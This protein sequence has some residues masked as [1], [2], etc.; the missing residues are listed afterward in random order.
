MNE[1]DLRTMIAIALAA[2]TFR[3]LPPAAADFFPPSFNLPG[4]IVTDDLLSRPPDGLHRNGHKKA[5]ETQN[6]GIFE[7]F[8][9][10]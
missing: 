7:V 2:F 1:A 9:H 3:P 4:S 10:F 6:K 5:Q 8:V